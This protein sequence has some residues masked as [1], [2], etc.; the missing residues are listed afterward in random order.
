MQK[1]K[2][3]VNRYPGSK[4]LAH[5]DVFSQLMKFTTLLKPHEYNFVPPTFTLP[6]RVDKQRL[7]LYMKEE[8]GATYIAKPQVGAKGEGM[9]LF[10]E[11]KD[12]PYSL[13]NREIVVQRYIDKPLLL[14]GI[15]FDIRVYVAVFGL[16]QEMR[17]YICNEGLA[18][19]CTV[20]LCPC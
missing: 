12:I 2:L 3:L 19:F 5:K 15:K 14:N 16:G 8:K 9:A 1:P 11:F 10:N 18:R 17:A 20:I 6:S 13:E 7:D 4:E